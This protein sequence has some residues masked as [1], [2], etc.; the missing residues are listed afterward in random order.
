M[1]AIIYTRY[2]GPEVLAAAEVEKPVPKDHEVLVKV[3]ATTVTAGDRRVR[4][5]D[6]P[7]GFKTLSRLIFGIFRPK[8]P[9]LGT[10]L[11]G[12]VESAGSK[13]T[14]FGVGDPVFAYSDSK[15]GAHAEYICLPED[16]AIALKP[17]NLGFGEAA[18]LSFGGATALN[19]FR[20]GGGLKRGEKVLVNGA[21]G[22]VGT[23]AIQLARH[24]GAAV[25]GVCS[26]R[27]VGLVESLGASKVIDYTKE[28]FT[29]NGETYDVIVDTAGTAP[30]SR[31][32]KSL[33]RGGR[34][35]KVL[36]TMP[37][38]L[39]APFISLI[40]D[41]KVVAGPASG[42]QKDLRFLAELTRKGEY[43]PVI[44]R[45]FPF[46]EMAE[47]HRYVDTG[48]KRGNVVVTVQPPKN[49]SDAA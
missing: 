10:E 4:S 1:K 24:F 19:F 13:V 42:N 21:S 20:R 6:V 48:R 22:A 15:M 37:D 44:D 17:V 26:T 11:S 5:L 40:S 45:R 2:G 43:S 46:E 29:K 32:K 47:A 8:Q 30:F 23:A 41:K 28:D 7:P 14:G 25:S 36:G 31:C 27:N 3:T 12:V 16:G 34:L 33:K 38:M 49:R 39:Q 18:A 9:I 35:L